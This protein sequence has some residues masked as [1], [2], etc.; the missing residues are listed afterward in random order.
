MSS[1]VEMDGLFVVRLS[2][3]GY[4]TSSSFNFGANSFGVG[5][6][7]SVTRMVVLATPEMATTASSETRASVF[8]KR[9]RHI[10]ELTALRGNLLGQHWIGASDH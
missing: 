2:D 9:K 6:S 4:A 8:S 7:G 3:K 10:G 5:V 1:Y